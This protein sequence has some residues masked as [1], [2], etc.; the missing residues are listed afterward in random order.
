[1]QR[2]LIPSFTNIWSM[3]YDMQEEVNLRCYVK[4]E[5]YNNL[6]RKSPMQNKENTLSSSLILKNVLA[7]WTM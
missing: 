5:L 4:Y 6:Q 3:F 1:M 7:S 2:S